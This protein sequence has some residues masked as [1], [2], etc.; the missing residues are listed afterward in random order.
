MP[1]G[2]AFHAGKTG[3]VV[4]IDNIGN[5][6]AAFSRKAGYSQKKTTQKLARAWQDY[7]HDPD[8]SLAADLLAI[9]LDAQF[10]RRVPDGHF[11]GILKGRDGDVRQEAYLLLLG[12][13]L[14]G[15]PG[16]LAATATGNR[17]AI[18]DEIQRS[19]GSSIRSVSKTLK[20]QMLRHE[21]IHAYG[22]DIDTHPKN[23][24]THPACRENI[25]ELPFEL[26]KQIVFASLRIAIRDNRLLARS[27]RVVMDMLEK[28][29]TQSQIAES[30][31]ISRQ[32]V[33]AILAPVR[34]HLVKVVA[35]QEF[36]LT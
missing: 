6:P 5:L 26:Q 24:C 14:G 1:F 10:K 18:V 16:L 15:N 21:K 17:Q 33:H 4:M 2:R 27:A 19:L 3:S 36:P 31:G 34:R 11:T 13:Y 25:W 7:C 30:Q 20:K 9:H 35:T 12:K 29:L 32:A 8:S 23:T 22:E 28:G